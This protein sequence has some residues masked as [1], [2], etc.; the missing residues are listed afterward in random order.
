MAVDCGFVIDHDEHYKLNKRSV[1]NG[2]LRKVQIN[3][4]WLNYK[5]R[6]RQLPEPYVPDEDGNR[7]TNNEFDVFME[8]D[9][10]TDD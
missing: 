6:Q 7:M 5:D 9:S 3:T 8:T 1:K 4:F 2:R 10:E